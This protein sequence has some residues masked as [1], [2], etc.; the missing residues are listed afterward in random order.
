MQQILLKDCV[1]SVWSHKEA[2]L[3]T[4]ANL[5]QGDLNFLSKVKHIYQPFFKP[6]G[7]SLVVQ[8]IKNLPAMQRQGFNPR[9]RKISWRRE[10][11]STPVFLPEEFHGQK[12]WWATVHGVARIGR[13][14]MT[15]T[16][17][18]TRCR[19]LFFLLLTILIFSFKFLYITVAKH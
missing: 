13:D 4:G 12:V 5:K 6:Y 19:W 16:L 14:C 15:N 11:L 7:A 18:F 3:W 2:T 1:Q 10:C 17:I 9:V 8:M